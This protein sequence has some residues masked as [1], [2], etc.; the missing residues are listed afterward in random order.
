MKKASSDLLLLDLNVLL[1]FHSK[2]R[3]ALSSRAGGFVRL[4][5][6][7]RRGLPSLAEIQCA[8]QVSKIAIP[9]RDRETTFSCMRRISTGAKP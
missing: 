2:A 8:V 9:R 5:S 3:E 1:A 6:K 4:S 7:E